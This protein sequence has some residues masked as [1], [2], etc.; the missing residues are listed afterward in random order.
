MKFEISKLHSFQFNLPIT[1]YYPVIS[2][3]TDT[4]ITTVHLHIY[5]HIC[6]I[7]NYNK[8]RPY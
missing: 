4:D 1:Y 8:P 7:I 2:N 5:N 3:V 6:D